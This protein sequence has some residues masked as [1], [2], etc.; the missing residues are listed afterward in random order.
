MITEESQVASKNFEE[1]KEEQILDTF[2]K[3]QREKGE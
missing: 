1:Y 3:G 2:K